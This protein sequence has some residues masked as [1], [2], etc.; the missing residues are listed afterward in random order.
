MIQN[1]RKVILLGVLRFVDISWGVITKSDFFY[2]F[3]IFFWG[4]G[5][6]FL[7]FLFFS[8]L[9]LFKVKIK[10]GNIFLGRKILNIFGYA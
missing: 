6:S 9:D 2:F 3:I 7:Y 8:I 4:G 10:N 1:L 5:G